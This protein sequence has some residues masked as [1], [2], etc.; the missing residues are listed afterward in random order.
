MQGSKAKTILNP[1]A[2]FVKKGAGG[3]YGLWQNLCAGVS[4]R[5]IEKFNC[6]YPNGYNRGSGGKKGFKCHELTRKEMSMV[7]LGRIIPN[8]NR[9]RVSAAK[10]KVFYPNLVA[11]LDRQQLTY[12]AIAKLLGRPTATIAGKLNGTNSLDTK[13]ALAIKEVLGVDIPLEELFKTVEGNTAPRVEYQGN[14]EIDGGI[15]L[16]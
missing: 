13:T 14:K 8:S 11:E 7:Q 4:R 16:A 15:F 3:L 9:L 2:V 10:R 6:I 5:R 1:C 12:V